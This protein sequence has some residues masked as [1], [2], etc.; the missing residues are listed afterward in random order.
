MLDKRIPLRQ[1]QITGQG[2]AVVHHRLGAHNRTVPPFI[3]ALR[4]TI[5]TDS[6]VQV[7]ATYPLPTDE[8]TP[9]VYDNDSDSDDNISVDDVPDPDNAPNRMGSSGSDSSHP[10]DMDDVESAITV[11]SKSL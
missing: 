2:F 3:A 10:G 5:H 11:H 4:A 7:P 1:I 8:F 9:P 6:K